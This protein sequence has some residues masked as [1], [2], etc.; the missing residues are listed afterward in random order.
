M[1][2]AVKHLAEP[3]KDESNTSSEDVVEGTMEEPSILAELV[4]VCTNMKMRKHS[5]MHLTS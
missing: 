3:E 2:N 1:Q 4:H 5:K